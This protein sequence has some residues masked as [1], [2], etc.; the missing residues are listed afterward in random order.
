[1]NDCS[2]SIEQALEEAEKFLRAGEVVHALTRYCDAITLHERHRDDAF[3]YG[4]ATA[5]TLAALIMV[6]NGG[7]AFADRAR[8]MLEDAIRD[9]RRSDSDERLQS[10]ATCMRLQAK[11]ARMVGGAADALHGFDI[12]LVLCKAVLRGE[13]DPDCVDVVRMQPDDALEMIA[14]CAEML[15]ACDAVVATNVGNFLSLVAQ[16]GVEIAVTHA[17]MGDA[18]TAVSWL[19]V[20]YRVLPYVRDQPWLAVVVQSY[21]AYTLAIGEFVREAEEL[22]GP[23]GTGRMNA[24]EFVLAG[25]RLEELSEM[26]P[27]DGAAFGNQGFESRL[28]AVRGIIE[29]GFALAQRDEIRSELEA[30]LAMP[31]YE[32]DAEARA[33]ALIT[34]AQ[35]SLAVDQ[36]PAAAEAALAEAIALL[37]AREALMALHMCHKLLGVALIRRGAFEQA[38]R[39]VGAAFEILMRLLG[40]SDGAEFQAEWYSAFSEIFGLVAEILHGRGALPPAIWFAKLAVAGAMRQLAHTAKLIPAL[41]EDGSIS[42]VHTR[43]VTNLVRFLAEDGRLGEALFFDHLDED[44]G[45]LPR[46]ANSTQDELERIPMTPAEQRH[47]ASFPE[48]IRRFAIPENAGCWERLLQE[49]ADDLTAE[50]R[51]AAETQQFV[52]AQFDRFA[53]SI[54]WDGSTAFLHYTTQPRSLRIAVTIQNCV[55]MVNVPIERERLARNLFSF[56]NAYSKPW[57]PHYMLGAA[58]PY[59]WLIAPIREVLER[60]GIRRLVIATTGVLRYFPFAA[61]HD[62]SAFLVERFLLASWS[63]AAGNVLRDALVAAPRIALLGRTIPSDEHGLPALWSVAGELDAIADAALSDGSANSVDVHLDP[64]FTSAALTEALY[65]ANVVHVASHFVAD[66]AHA[67]E[68]W[69]LLGDGT[70]WRL[71]DLTAPATGPRPLDV[72]MLTLSACETGLPAGT[73]PAVSPVEVF[74]TL[75]VRSVIST[76]W[77]VFSESTGQVMAKLYRC[78]FDEGLDKAQ[79]LRRAQLMLLRGEGSERFTHPHYWAPFMLSGNWLGLSPRN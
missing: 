27:S 4:I 68:S 67:A 60:A 3:D 22:Y 30:L 34:S 54:P 6:D 17:V 16:I 38:S 55:H 44:G 45:V 23:D 18:R 52:R 69:L 7:L 41:G 57:R 76:L 21:S 35:F 40:E 29:S 63:V 74:H 71:A 25:E 72:D 49:A 39:E 11:L 24:P 19:E 47:T 53:A 2:P 28:G 58:N 13:S 48:R 36:N 61:L 65:R 79:A 8:I 9:W 51:P 5:R 62:G 66:P 20:P 12:A 50:A 42:G 32:R 56:L 14:E 1:V 77:P 73:D 37:S 46:L 10:L 31:E 26:L 43:S 33:V 59:V 78:I 15:H 70:Q 75:G 64:A